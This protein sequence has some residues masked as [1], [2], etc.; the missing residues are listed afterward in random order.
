LREVSRHIGLTAPI[1]A[2]SELDLDLSEC[3]GP[4]DWG[5]VVCR[6]TGA[7]R[8]LNAVGGSAL[9]DPSAFEKDGVEL[10]FL[11]ARPF[12]YP[13]L[14]APHESWLSIFDVLMFRSADEVRELC[15]AMDITDAAGAPWNGPPHP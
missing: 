4:G 14:G 3:T 5:R 8:Y 12:E 2:L 7:D 11:R 10:T 9:F 13:Q 15:M 6:E 1:E